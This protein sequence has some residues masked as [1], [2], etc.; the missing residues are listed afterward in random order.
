[1]IALI[2]NAHPTRQQDRHF[3][4]QSFVLLPCLRRKNMTERPALLLRIAPTA[5]DICL[6]IKNPKVDDPN[7]KSPADN[8][9]PP[10]VIPLARE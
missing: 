1:L 6:E 10:P 9:T 4:G 7:N 5:K 3:F 2:I 8:V